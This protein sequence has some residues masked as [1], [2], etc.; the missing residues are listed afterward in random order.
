MV[1]VTGFPQGGHG[2]RNG[3]F[4]AKAGQG[5]WDAC[6]I[7]VPAP[8]MQALRGK[9]RVPYRARRL[10]SASTQVLTS[11][12]KATG[13]DLARW[14]PSPQSLRVASKSMLVP[15]FPIKGAWS[16]ASQGLLTKVESPRRG[17]VEKDFSVVVHIAQP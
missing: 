10:E 17:V 12:G 9:W 4:P 1:Q 6:A 3:D 5:V 2:W 13:S 15:M 16:T 14:C 7:E 8:S 11:L